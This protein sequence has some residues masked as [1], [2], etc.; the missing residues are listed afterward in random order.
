MCAGTDEVFRAGGDA[1]AEALDGKHKEEVT[2]RE[3]FRYVPLVS[4]VE[5]WTQGYSKRYQLRVM[6]KP[7]H[8][9]S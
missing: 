5:N 1:L 8:K 4:L 7:D 9:D 6:L 3:I 2:D